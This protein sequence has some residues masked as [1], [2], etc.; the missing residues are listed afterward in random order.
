MLFK[1]R[2]Q[3]YLSLFLSL[4]WPSSIIGGA[5]IHILCF[6]SLISFEIHEYSL[7][8]LSKLAAPLVSVKSNPNDTFV[9]YDCHYSV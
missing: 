8:Q 1:I 3:K 4:A 5:N 2:I 9:A 7:L 6:A